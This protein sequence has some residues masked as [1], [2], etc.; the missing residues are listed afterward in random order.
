MLLCC[1]PPFAGA[2]A[3]LW[4]SR[5]SSFRS[6]LHDIFTSSLLAL[7]LEILSEP[8]SYNQKTKKCSCDMAANAERLKLII[9]RLG[10]NINK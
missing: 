4:S 3:M 8:F 10:Q 2:G 5:A 1:D 9:V 7:C 6:N